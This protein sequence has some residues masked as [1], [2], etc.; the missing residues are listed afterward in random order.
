MEQN[1]E[2]NVSRW[3]DE[4]LA[5]LRPSGEWPFD[6]T[7]ALARFKDERARRNSH[8]GRWIW[9]A[10][11]TMTVVVCLLAFPAPRVF[12]QR[13]VNACESFFVNRT[14]VAGD[15]AV[16]AAA[17]VA[18]QNWQPAPDFTL[19]DL[20]GTEIRLSAYRGKVVL[21]NFWATWCVPCQAEV[22]W[23]SEFARTYGSRGF[24]VI[25]IS[26][27]EDGRTSVKPYLESRKVNYRVALG[28]DTLAQQYGGLN[29]LPE[30]LLIDK[31]GRIAARHIG[32][33]PKSVYEH[34]IIQ[35][36]GMN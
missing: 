19:E 16:K 4:R 32:L 27:D 22:P 6:T 15:P 11:V 31:E 5:I 1:S 10:A 18:Q 21:L 23:F 17:A 26:M 29:A 36:L 35:L 30:T 28:N 25:G 20:H 33:V 12:A 34:E 9:A 8:G 7:G 14:A 24:E 13:C 2:V 3:V